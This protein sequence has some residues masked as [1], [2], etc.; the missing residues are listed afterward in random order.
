MI[1]SGERT[2]PESETLHP[3]KLFTHHRRWGC[4]LIALFAGL[5]AASCARRADPSPKPQAPPPFEFLGAW[6][7]KGEGPGKLDKPVAFAVD[8]LGR[9][10]LRT[11]ARVS[12][13]N[14]NRAALRCFPLRILASFMLRESPWTAAAPSTS[15]T[16]SAG[17]S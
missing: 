8:A 6:G 12:F 17:T 1:L 14:S 7:D 9:C 13:T 3:A 4:L 5:F 16:R 15:L 10:S 11:L 2:I